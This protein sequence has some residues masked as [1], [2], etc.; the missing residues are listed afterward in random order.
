VGRGL[1]VMWMSTSPD[2]RDDGTLA[3]ACT[4]KYIKKITDEG[5]GDRH[6]QMEWGARKHGVGRTRARERERER[7][8]E[9]VCMCVCV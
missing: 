2:N 9:R 7:E 5:P 6:N 4:S 1:Q 3:H 8:R